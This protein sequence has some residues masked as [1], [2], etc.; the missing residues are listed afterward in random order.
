MIIAGKMTAAEKLQLFK[1]EMEWKCWDHP[2]LHH[3]K[4]CQFYDALKKS[5]ILFH[6]FQ[7]KSNAFWG[8][9]FI[10]PNK[11]EARKAAA[12]MGRSYEDSQIIPYYDQY[13]VCFFV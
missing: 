3:P 5:N 12:L 2:P 1:K 9:R 6:T 13:A 4:G 8:T 10:F 11:K 7:A